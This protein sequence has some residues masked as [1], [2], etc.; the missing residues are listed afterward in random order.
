MFFLIPAGTVYSAYEDVIIVNKNT[1]LYKGNWNVRDFVVREYVR[2]YKTSYRVKVYIKSKIDIV[3]DL[4][5]VYI[6]EVTP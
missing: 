3:S 5:S 4:E 6:K 2:T 1:F